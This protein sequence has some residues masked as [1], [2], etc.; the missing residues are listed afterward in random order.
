MTFEANGQIYEL[1][2][3]IRAL[4]TIEDVFQC[5]LPEL[6]KRFENGIGINELVKFIQIG[7]MHS[8]PNI[9]ME[10]VDTIIDD[11]G[12]EKAAELFSAAFQEA[13]QKKA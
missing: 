5:P 12:I 13:F 3:N 11:I 10:Q 6:Q 4:R 7:L 9:T 1:K 2:Y 8:I